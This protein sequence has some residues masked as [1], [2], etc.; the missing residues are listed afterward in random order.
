MKFVVIAVMMW[1][2]LLSHAG[3][4][5]SPG[6]CEWNSPGANRYTGEVAAAIRSYVELPYDLR[7]RLASRAEHRQYDEVVTISRDAIEG[8]HADYYEPDIR[9]MHFGGRGKVCDTVDRSKWKADDIERGLVYCEDFTCVLIPTV[10]TNVSLIR[11]RAAQ[12]L[13]PLLPLQPL[14]ALESPDMQALAAPPSGDAPP[15]SFESSASPYGP[16]QGF[17]GG[18]PGGFYGGSSGTPGVIGGGCPCPP[19][20]H[21]PSPIP[22][23]GTWAM[24]GAGLAVMFFRARKTQWNRKIITTKT[25]AFVR[26]T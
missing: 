5:G 15:E 18:F 6:R 26:E 10:C 14:E 11:R 25:G 17:Y 1:A 3:P 19:G 21:T 20:P 9:R 12:A 22:E 23:P 24:F 7:E 2:P 13:D 16:N 8:T 4:A